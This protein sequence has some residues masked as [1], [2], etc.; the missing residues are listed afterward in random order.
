MSS[1]WPFGSDA[2]PEQHGTEASAAPEQVTEASGA[3]GSDSLPDGAAEQQGTKASGNSEQVKEASG[4][5]SSDGLTDAAVEQPVE[6]DGFAGVV[7][8][9]DAELEAW[10]EENPSG[11]TGEPERQ[12]TVAYSVQSPEPLPW[13]MWSPKR[14]Y[15]RVSREEA[16]AVLRDGFEA[17]M[18]ARAQQEN[19]WGGTGLV[20][21]SAWKEVAQAEGT[22]TS[23]VGFFFVCDVQPGSATSL[24]W[25]STSGPMEETTFD[26]ESAYWV[27]IY[28][29][30]DHLQESSG[31]FGSGTA[32]LPPLVAGSATRISVKQL[33]GFSVPGTGFFSAWTG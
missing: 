3:P 1:W 30:A 21:E 13:S 32:S 10:R 16:Q 14:L 12:A 7:K 24:H 27:Y 31:V 19:R 4:A 2:T 17:A 15:L 29:N 5:P 22:F 8:M 28:N 26:G 18:R 23:T 6:V 9:T 25:D 33:V 11:D 20:L